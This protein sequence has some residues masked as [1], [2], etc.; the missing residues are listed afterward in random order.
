MNPYGSHLSPG[1][2]GED[3]SRLEQRD[4]GGSYERPRLVRVGRL[5]DLVAGGAGSVDEVSD[6]SQ[7][8]AGQPG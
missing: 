1:G 7:K 5:R 2:T 4:A 8:H 6:F 3:P